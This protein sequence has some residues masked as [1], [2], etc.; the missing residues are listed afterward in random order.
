MAMGEKQTRYWPDSTGASIVYAL[1][2]TET[3]STSHS[4]VFIAELAKEK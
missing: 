1:H 3:G 2:E 4:D